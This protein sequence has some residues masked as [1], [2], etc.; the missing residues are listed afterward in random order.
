MPAR[1][2]SITASA[3]RP[4]V[5]A[6]NL[7]VFGSGTLG[8]LTKWTGFTSSSSSIGDSIIFED[9]FGKVGIGTDTPTSRL[10][11]AGLIETTLGGLKFPDGTVQTTSA[12]DALLSVA[13][14]ATLQGN[15]TAGSLLGIAVPLSLTGTG[16]Q[17]LT[18][19][20][21]QPSGFGIAGFGGTSG[22]GIGGV[23][24]VG[25]TLPGG[26]G[27][28]GRG[29]RSQSASGGIGVEAVGG[30]S[31]SDQGGDA[32]AARGGNSS[33]GL[34]G[35]AVNALGGAS[36]SRGGGPAVTA[37]G[38]GSGI[39]L[40]G[41][42]IVATGG[43]SNTGQGGG[44]VG[45]F[46]GNSVVSGNGGIGML[47]VG[48]SGNG[49]G[50]SSG[51]GLRAIGGSGVNGAGNGLAATFEGDVAVN[52]NLSKGGG[53]FKIDHPLDPE[54]RYL[55]HSFVVS[56]DMK[57]IYDGV[58]RLDGSGEAIIA[59]PEWF[60][61]LNRDFRYL[62]TPIGT[63]MPGLYIAEEVQDNRFRVAGGQPGMKV[64]WQVTGIRQDSYANKNRIKVEEEKAEQERGFYLH[65]EAFNQPE[66]R[67]VEWARHPEMMRQ[68]KETRLKQ[69]E[70]L[71]QKSQSND[72]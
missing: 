63:P 18:V 71:K 25:E 11:V 48:G 55:Y 20:N 58:T 24:G 60:S 69:L 70:N 65:P 12:A 62:L 31:T 46:G 5:A 33:T 8:R 41:A 21:N 51:P 53:S 19:S 9:K 2:A 22:T 38:G 40:G 66:E 56:P 44:G 42:G 61:A 43:N 64:S 13:H 37:Q 10:T 50:H 7:Q 45:G 3:V 15:G 30:N 23:G 39:S 27:I 29:G 14:D 59:M 28:L 54:N 34:G 6:A 68:M 17:L 47:A 35:N 16:L 26:T 36:D 52:G 4:I 72:R 49:A 57:N 1:S 32:V 67:G